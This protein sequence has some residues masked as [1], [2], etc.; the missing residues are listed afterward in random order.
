[1][2]HDAHPT[3]RNITQPPDW[4]DAF[5]AAA[6]KEGMSLAAWLGDA[7]RD[8]LPAR[9]RRKLSP[10]RTAGRPRTITKG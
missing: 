2:P 9:V 7:A 10:R 8:K 5:E 6:A 1:M 4:W 3:R